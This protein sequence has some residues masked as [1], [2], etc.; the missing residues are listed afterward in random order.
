M[1]LVH[2]NKSGGTLRGQVRKRRH[3]HKESLQAF[4]FSKIPDTCTR[5]VQWLRGSRMQN[6]CLPR[7]AG[8][9]SSASPSGGGKLRSLRKAALALPVTCP[10]SEKRCRVVLQ[11]GKHAFT[12]SQKDTENSQVQGVLQPWEGTCA[13]SPVATPFPEWILLRSSQTP[14]CLLRAQQR[15]ELGGDSALS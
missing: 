13:L 1:R 5:I 6:S 10:S 11:G 12:E 7:W 2:Q 8:A 3:K 9:G 14:S 4:K 15:V